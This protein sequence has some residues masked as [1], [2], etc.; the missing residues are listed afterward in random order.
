MSLRGRSSS[1]RF[2]TASL[3]VWTRSG[4]VTADE[5]DRHIVASTVDLG[6]NLRLCTVAEGVEERDT[7]ERLAQM[8][9]VQA[10]GFDS[11]ARS[12]PPTWK[13]G[14]VATPDQDPPRLSSGHF[15][16]GAHVSACSYATLEA[17]HAAI[18]PLRSRC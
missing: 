2:P 18:R 13:S 17:W 7:Y 14:P 8:G 6:R 4:A 12:P 16:S 11:A 3:L 10:Q 15:A 1:R 9:C 5:S